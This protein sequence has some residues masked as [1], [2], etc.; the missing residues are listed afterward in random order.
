VGLLPPGPGDHLAVADLAAGRAAHPVPPGW[1]RPG[2]TL[3]LLADEISRPQ[4]GAAA[5]LNRVVDILFV[6]LL[7]A[8]LV[9]GLARDHTASWLSALTDPSPARP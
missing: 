7:R 2:Y 8:W 5:V 9:A 4:P 3:R 1:H 6:Q